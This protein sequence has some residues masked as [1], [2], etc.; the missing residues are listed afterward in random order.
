MVAY[1]RL[2]G[3]GGGEEEEDKEP[4]ISIKNYINQS[5]KL[6]CM[7][8]LHLFNYIPLYFFKGRG[9]IVEETKKKK[10]IRFLVRFLTT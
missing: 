8:I 2:G 1:V 6:N 7:Q 9:N 10:K 5:I 3:G 4:R